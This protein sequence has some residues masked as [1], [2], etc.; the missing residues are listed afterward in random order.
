MLIIPNISFSQGGQKWAVNGNN[1]STGNYFGTNNNQPLLFY[2]N[3]T[4]KMNLTSSGMLGIG[5]DNPQVQLHISDK[6]RINSFAN[7]NTGFVVFD[8]QGTLIPKEFPGNQN[9][10]MLGDGSFG[11]VP[12]L[13]WTVSGNNLISSVSGN[14]GIG[15]SPEAKLDVNGNAIIRGT[16][17]VYDGIIVGRKYTGEKV[18][19]DSVKSQLLEAQKINVD[20]IEASEKIKIQ[21]INIDGNASKITSSTGLI[22]FADENLKTTGTINATN[23]NVSGSTSF[24]NI[25]ANQSITIGTSSLHLASTP[26][27]TGYH[28]RIYASNGFLMLQSEISND[29]NTII[30]ANNNG[31]VC[32]GAINGGFGC[33]DAC[34]RMKLDVRG[35]AR[36][37]NIDG[38]KYV[39]VGYKGSNA[40]IDHYEPSGENGKLLINYF[41]GRDVVIGGDGN[42]G[43]SNTGKFYTNHDTYLALQDARVGI[44]T[45]SPQQNLHL[46]GKTCVGCMLPQPL[47]TIMRIE[48]EIVDVDGNYISNAWWDMVVTGS[49]PNKFHFMSSNAVDPEKPILTLYD[50]GTVSIPGMATGSGSG[51][52]PVYVDALGNLTV[53]EGISI[54]EAN[55]NNAFKLEGNIGIGVDPTGSISKLSI[56]RT[57]WG[58]WFHLIRSDNS[59]WRF[60]DDEAN[61]NMD[62]VYQDVNGSTTYGILVINK[63]GNIGIGTN[64]ISDNYKLS[65]K[66]KL[67]AEE[68]E[69]YLSSSWADF[70]F[71]DNYK[72][73][74]LK[75]VEEFIINNKHL[76]D[77]PSE[78]EVKENGI[79]LGEMDK[80]LLQ[81]IEELT[82]YTIEQQKEI[83][84][85]KQEMG[86]ITKCSHE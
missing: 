82:L 64:S 68:I 27:P 53:G 13:G 59:Y 36:F 86:N 83:E 34:D 32:I 2:T 28:N 40:V 8:N 81:K 75:E 26:L 21:T 5:V 14:V 6:L 57:N 66:G 12:G 15:I 17:H 52:K 10:V 62:I 16:L 31:I 61:N 45:I 73:R 77:V 1:L 55:G 33:L 4:E 35:D 47:S 37:T 79:N 69:V 43:A 22:D 84:R 71:E 74:N 48:D 3:G 11:T 18:D 50:N 76:P 54:W 25:N 41:S 29:F 80:I 60:H 78:Q 72:L 67:R 19:V 56:K 20:E 63:N 46:K 39:R 24:D 44:G 30:N 70:V 23:L 9:L 58:D 38:T 85:L 7:Y 51:N 65:V 49:S 42:G